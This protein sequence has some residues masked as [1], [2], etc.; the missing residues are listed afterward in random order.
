MSLIIK[1]NNKPRSII[2]GYE[3]TE[4]EQAEFDYINDIESA[5]FF[6]YKGSLYDLWD[7]IHINRKRELLPHGFEY[8]HGY[9]SDSFFSGLLVKYT[10]DDDCVI[11]G[12]YY[13]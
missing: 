3:L 7:F 5:Q 1:T 11:V 8:W 10:N 2:Y 9:K 4:K 12:T 6:R 13:S